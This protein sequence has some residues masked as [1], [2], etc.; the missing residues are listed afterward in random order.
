MPVDG[1]PAVGVNLHEQLCERRG[2]QAVPKV[3]AQF[4]IERL[5]IKLAVMLLREI[6]MSSS[7]VCPSER[8]LHRS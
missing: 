3:W 2:R 8:V 4:L 6:G 5:R 7:A 1:A